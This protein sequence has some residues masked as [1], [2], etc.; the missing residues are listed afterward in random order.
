EPD[1][2][3]ELAS[4]LIALSSEYGFALFLAHATVWHGW[5]RALQEDLGA[6]LE[7]MRRGAEDYRATGAEQKRSYQLGILAEA[8]ARG[9]DVEEGHRVLSEAR[10]ATKGGVRFFEAELWR[11]EGDLSLAQ[12]VR[13][14]PTAERRVVQALDVAGRQNAR[15]WE[16][17]AATSLARLW[18]TQG[19]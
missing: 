15:S 16:L 12:R 19:R 2:T 11:L 1:E 4:H 6:G 13:D 8:M 7:D 5:A 18:Q 17:R 10:E 9:G 3:G 14:E